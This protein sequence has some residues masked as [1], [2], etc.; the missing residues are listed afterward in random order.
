MAGWD[1]LHNRYSRY[2]RNSLARFPIV[3]VILGFIVIF[4]AR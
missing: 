4:P 2:L 1:S 3:I